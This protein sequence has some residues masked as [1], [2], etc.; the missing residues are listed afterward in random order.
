MLTG[1]V[2]VSVALLGPTAG[3][4]I[5]DG[6]FDDW[7]TAPLQ[8]DD[9]ADAPGAVV[10]LKQVRVTHDNRFVHVL[11]D[12]GRPVN[13]QRL[14]GTIELL[15]DL[16]ASPDSGQ[17]VR[18][19]PGVDAIVELS[20]LS[21]D[22]PGRAGRGAALGVPLD[23][24]PPGDRLRLSPYV[25]GLS[26][27]PTYA[28]DRF[29]LRLQRDAPVP[30]APPFLAE[31]RFAGRLDAL[32]LR[33]EL[34]DRTAT[35]SYE[36]T[37][38]AFDTREQA[39]DPLAR[40]A[41]TQ[42]RVVSWNAEIGRLFDNPDPFARVLAAIDPD[43][44][45]LQE[46]TADTTAEQLVQLLEQDIVPGSRWQAVVAAGGGDLR[47]AVASR[48]ALR[49]VAGLEIVAYP[50]LP[51]SSIRVAAAAIDVHGRR[52]LALSV[53]LRCCGRAGSFED[54]TRVVEA[55]AIRRAVRRTLADGRFDGVV[56]A[57][58][59]NIVG[60]RWP[61]DVLTGDTGIDGS[62]LDVADTLQ[63][64]GDSNATW[65]DPRQPFVPGRLDYLLY[66][67]RSLELR[68]G[69]VLDALDLALRWLEH[70]RL[71]VRDTAAASDHLPLVIDLRWRPATR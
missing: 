55:D 66:G 35:F 71:E 47:C 31:G 40:A 9:P 24:P 20:P 38:V 46:L 43:V 7:T 34:L 59:F 28:G 64:D 62:P 23:Q 29:E 26:F 8:L 15:L 33:G 21:P 2:F 25:I 19:M 49:P 16:D 30:M 3:H 51:E 1:L 69:F 22:H 70:H 14:D 42:L 54:R 44:I 17:T 5:L 27:A 12:V 52:L 57:G 68:G 32:D 41:G 56:V 45:L 18:G 39:D 63:I 36:L 4:V 53:H 48:A 13:V 50:D 67:D 37:P 6:R 60:S 61:L 58:D 65:A 11:I 10:D